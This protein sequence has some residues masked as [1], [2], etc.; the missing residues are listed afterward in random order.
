MPSIPSP[1]DIYRLSLFLTLLVF[2]G[3]IPLR[4]LCAGDSTV[5]IDY[6]RALCNTVQECVTSSVLLTVYHRVCAGDSAEYDSD[7]MVRIQC[8][9]HS[10]ESQAPHQQNE[11]PYRVW[12]CSTS[13]IPEFDSVMLT[14]SQSLALK[15]WSDRVWSHKKGGPQS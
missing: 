12:P 14:R 6:E 11:L 8:F 7:L 5:K 2:A 4:S 13:N 1:N 9:S 10:G 15:C 3:L